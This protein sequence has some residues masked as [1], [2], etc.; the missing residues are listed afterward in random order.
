MPSN[1][2]NNKEVQQIDPLD[3]EKAKNKGDLY[4]DPVFSVDDEYPQ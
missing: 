1:E 3:V 2:K 4:G